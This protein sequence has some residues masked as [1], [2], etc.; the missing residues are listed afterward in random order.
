MTMCE[1]KR[2]RLTAAIVVH[3]SLGEHGVVFHLSLADGRA[4]I[5]DDDQ[6]ACMREAFE[7]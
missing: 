3:T 6:L 4:I 2:E 5:G 7:R 1:Q